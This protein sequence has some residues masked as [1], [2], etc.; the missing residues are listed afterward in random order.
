MCTDSA[1]PTTYLESA[2]GSLLGCSS[3]VF[4]HILR[5]WVKVPGPL[6][7]RDVLCPLL[8]LPPT[9][10]KNLGVDSTEEWLSWSVV[11]ARVHRDCGWCESGRRPLQRKSSL[12]TQLPLVRNEETVGEIFVSL[13][14]PSWQNTQWHFLR[15]CKVPLGS[16]FQKLCAG[17]ER[18]GQE[19]E[20]EREM[21]GT[22]EIKR[23]PQ[24]HTLFNYILPPKA[25][26]PPNANTKVSAANLSTDEARPSRY[27][28]HSDKAPPC[29]TGEH[30]RSI[31]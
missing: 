8:A 22:K 18:G 3:G 17:V 11:P 24:G 21:S 31:P 9:G 16:L 23:R 25:L 14:L 4:P 27:G 1:L 10:E 29:E 26:L 15:G 13:S 5:T 28:C 12:T 2:Q 20:R 6:F 30:F 19:V 7:V